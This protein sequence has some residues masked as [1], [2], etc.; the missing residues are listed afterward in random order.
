MDGEVLGIELL[1]LELGIILEI[2]YIIFLYV[3]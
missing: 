2:Y 1:K 3:V